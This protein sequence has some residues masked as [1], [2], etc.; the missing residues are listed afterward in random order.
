MKRIGWKISTLA[1]ALLVVLAMAQPTL[2][3]AQAA[4]PAGTSSIHGHVLNPA[5]FPLTKGE[6]R[7]STDRT[8]EAKDRKYL[9][10]FPID[11]NG[12]Y[13]GS[14]IVAGTYIVFVF[15]DDKSLDFNENVPIAKEEDKLV[16]FD[17]SRPEYLSK[18][19]PEER[20]QIE[21]YKK[22]NSEV[23]ATNAK[24][25]NLNAL[26]TQARADN[27]AGNYD[28]AITAMKQAT[29][30]KP[31][32]GILWVTLGDAQLGSGE[33]AAKAAKAAGTSPTDPAILQKYTDA[34]SSYKKAADL[35]AAS[36][37]PNPETA[38]VAYNQLG[39]AEARL[40]DAKASSDAYEQAAKAQ[41]EKAG[42]Y[43]FN[44]A[45]TLY[46]AGKLPEASA[47]ADKAIAADPKKADAYYI[48]GQALIPQATV[49]PKT[50]K[51]VAPPG[52]VEAYQQY[53]ELAPDGAHAADVK[54]I[55]EG[56]GAPIKSTFKA[57]K[58]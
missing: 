40:G 31:D 9:Y 42:M 52:C 10:T 20:K 39:Q 2:L 3:K 47:A 15:Q 33:T 34:A 35:N 6:V 23:S 8:S 57:G 22:K 56:I 49:D 29:D 48:K 24:I 50:Q 58:K 25:Q 46:N 30:T 38:G 11:A 12:D 26:L 45:A 36:K 4:P 18:M 21:E 16:N 37:K 43:Y 55:L 7:L 32:E 13:K 19:T 14:G 28:S 27:K 17:M 54:G 5:G 51:I 41:P 44:E 53:L 1:A